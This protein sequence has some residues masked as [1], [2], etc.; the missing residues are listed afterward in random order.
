MQPMPP[1]YLWVG[2][3]LLTGCATMTI[4]TEHAPDARFAH[5]TAY[6]RVP[7]LGVSSDPQD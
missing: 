5:L 7:E 6:D 3:V 1:R 4:V 2:V